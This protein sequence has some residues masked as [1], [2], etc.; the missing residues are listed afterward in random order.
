M[1]IARVDV[2]GYD[3]T[4]RYGSYTMSGGRVI[5]RLA[6]TIVRVTTDE[7]LE[8]FGEVCPLGPAYLPAHGEGPFSY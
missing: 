4:Y 1:R 7:G 8:G 5:D 3:L 6:S 2:Y